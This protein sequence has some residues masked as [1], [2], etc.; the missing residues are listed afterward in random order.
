[1]KSDWQSL[2]PGG[3]RRDIVIDSDTGNETD[4][5]FA[6]A[7][8]LLSPE[9]FRVRAIYAAPF[10]HF[11]V[12]TAG[13][14]M[15]ESHAEIR[16]LVSMIPE[17]EA[18]VFTGATGFLADGGR[19]NNPAARHLVELSR[20]YSAEHPLYIVAIAALTNIAAAL[21]LDP[22]LAERC[23]ML[24]LGSQNY[25]RGP[26]EFNFSGDL[27]ATQSVLESALPV[28]LFPCAGIAETLWLDDA[29][30][31]RELLSRGAL[32]R[33]LYNRFAR[34]TGGAPT[35][36]TAIW[37]IAPFVALSHPE[38][39]RMARVPKRRIDF[40]DLTWREETGAMWW[41]NE[42]LEVP[43]IFAD[44]FA[45]L[46]AHHRKHPELREPRF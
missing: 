1:M 32:G 4:D 13:E 20:A 10:L 16:R 33:F 19:E 38:R 44:L 14:G 41:M 12:A 3:V 37:D 45:R 26:A 46:D 31:R 36:A 5:Q 35:A 2:F 34:M 6:I 28:H 42:A 27:A 23:E 29:T 15:M 8:V 9:A 7:L 30:A 43:A 39:V 11:R 25:E 40:A 24:W 17:A 18:P 22:T 21:Q